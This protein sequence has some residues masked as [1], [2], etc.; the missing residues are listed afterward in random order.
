M[1]DYKDITGAWEQLD[2]AKLADNAHD[3]YY[4]WYQLL[5]VYGCF[6]S[7]N[8]LSYSY[9]QMLKLQQAK[10]TPRPNSLAGGV[11]TAPPLGSPA[12]GPQRPPL[13]PNGGKK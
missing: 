10:G 8:S 12:P 9:S 6:S 1:A 3:Q 4:R 5:L 11:P 7:L 2:P 13:K